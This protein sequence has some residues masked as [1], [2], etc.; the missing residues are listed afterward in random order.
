MMRKARI[1]SVLTVLFAGAWGLISGTQTWLHVALKNV[2]D[3]GLEV[4]GGAAIAMLTPFSLAALALGA[5][6]SIVGPIARVVLGLL[7]VAIGSTML[8]LNISLIVGDKADAVAPTVSAATGI[9]GHNST[10]VLVSTI[11][12]TPWVWLALI[13]WVLL[14]A[15]GLFVAVTG[16]KWPASGRKYAATQVTHHSE[17]PL[18]AVDSWD[19]LSRGDDPTS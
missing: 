3:A 10:A 12:Q 14:V 19:E 5:A 13:S 9:S 8:V 15:A 17:G 11:T 1:V 18:D 7:A 4:A 16:R 6:L 2:T